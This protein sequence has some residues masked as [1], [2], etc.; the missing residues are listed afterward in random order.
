[1]SLWNA[2]SRWVRQSPCAR[3]GAPSDHAHHVLT[4]AAYPELGLCPENVLPLCSGCHAMAHAEPAAFG[5]WLDTYKP[6]LKA[7]LRRLARTEWA[8]KPLDEKAEAVR[9]AVEVA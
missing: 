4:R 6:G 1:M 3:C 8:G 2:L 7:Y 9:R 5:L